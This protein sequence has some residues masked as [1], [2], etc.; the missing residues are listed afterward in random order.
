MTVLPVRL[1]QYESEYAQIK[2]LFAQRR[3][4]ST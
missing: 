2:D 1:A 3:H 4:K